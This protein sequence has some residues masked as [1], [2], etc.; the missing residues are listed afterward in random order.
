VRKIVVT[1]ERMVEKDGTINFG[2]FRRPFVNANILDAPLYSR[3]CRVPALWK[4]FRLKEWQH[5]GIITPTHY[6]GMVIFNAKFM[7]VSFFYAYDR[8]RNERIE[9]SRQGG[10]KSAQVASQVYDDGCIFT[11]KGYSLK[12]ENKLSSGFHKIIIDVDGGNNLTAVKGEIKVYEDLGK[13]EPLV[14]VSPITSY[15]PLYTHKAAM[16][17]SGSI[18]LGGQEI[19]IDGNQ[20]IALIDE[21]KTYYP[22]FSFWKWATAAGYD[23]SGRLLAFNLCQNMIAADEEF[24]ENCFWIDGKISCLP[25]ARFEFDKIMEPWKVKTTNENLQLTFVPHGERTQKINLAGLISSDYHQPFGL[26]NGVFKDEQGNIYP[27]QDFFG[28]AEHHITRY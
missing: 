19:V 24:N 18:I 21:Q 25:A 22:Y 2:T 27:V 20:A 7:G 8:L 26:Y 11:Q 13:I 1:P 10:G 28:L 15:R 4:N 17:A 23:E 14:Q 12:F 5:F 9:Q 6:F 16:P 3:S